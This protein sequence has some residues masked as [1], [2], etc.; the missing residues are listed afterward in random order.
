MIELKKSRQN[1]FKKLAKIYSDEYSKTPFNEPWTIKKAIT[2]LK[3]FSK[4]CDIYSI[5]ENKKLIGFIIINPSCWC[6]GEIVFGEEMAI[7]D[8]YQRKGIATEVFNEIFK[9]YKK[10]GYK[11]YLG[12]VNK[13]SKSFGLHKK[14]G[15]KINKSDFLME[16]ELK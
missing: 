15:C 1:E 6:P 16:K 4:Y 11:R 8:K 13:N 3:I 14:I 5:F 9:I 7:D 12:I 2:K 10:K